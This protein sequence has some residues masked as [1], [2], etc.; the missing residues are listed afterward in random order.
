VSP[1]SLAFGALLASG[2]LLSVELAS[3]GLKTPLSSSLVPTFRLLGEPLQ[4]LDRL[5]GRVLPIDEL[6]E[7]ELGLLLRER[8]EAQANPYDLEFRYVNELLGEIARGASRPFEYRA[9]VAEGYTAN[10]FALPGGTIVVTRGL[11][12]TLHSEAELAAVLAHELAHVE[13][14]HCFSAVKLELLARKA[15]QATLGRLADLGYALLL[16]HAFSKAQED[17]ADQYAYTWM[18]HGPYDPRGQARAFDSLLAYAKSQG[19]VRSVGADPLRDYVRSHPPLELRRAEFLERAKA[20]WRRHRGEARY[21]GRSNLAR[22]RSL[23][24]GAITASEWVRS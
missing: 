22:R 7:L 15:D 21:V 24:S 1:R 17:E 5:A 3:V 18:E 20:W 16:R 19:E 23:P 6:D 4:A 12:R 9:Y 14:G 8:Y 11:L 13:L 10:A 2:L